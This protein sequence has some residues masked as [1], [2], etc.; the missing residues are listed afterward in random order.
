MFLIFICRRLFLD[1]LFF[2]IKFRMNICFKCFINNLG[3][4]GF[5]GIEIIGDSMFTFKIS[6]T[7]LEWDVVKLNLYVSFFFKI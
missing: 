4:L 3:F 1:L 2:V 6:F 7:V 5:R